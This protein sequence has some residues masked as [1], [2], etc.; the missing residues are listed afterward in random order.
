MDPRRICVVGSTN[1]DVV[2]HVDRL[3][4]PGE[5]LMADSLAISPGGKGAN[6]A[7]AAAR[8]GSL[9]RFSTR[10]GRDAFGRALYDGLLEA[11]IE[12]DSVLWDDDAPT[13]VAGI[14][15]DASG[16]N[17]ITVAA[18]ANLRLTAE[19]ASAA[20]SASTPRVVLAQLE[21]PV[22]AV[23]AAFEHRPPGCL[24]VLNP[25][26]APDFNLPDR[27]LRLT[28][29][30]TPNETETERLT[31]IRPVDAATCLEA[32][33]KLRDR[34]AGAVVITRGRSGCFVLD[35]SGYEVVQG[36]AVRA[37]DSTAAGDAFNGALA[38]SLARGLSLTEAAGF[39][40][41]AAA[42]SVTRRGAQAAMPTREEVDSAALT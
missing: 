10:L 23:Q 21:V 3:P 11:G 39:A 37:V 33:I 12:A 40:N 14:L 41:R 7:V 2:F 19:D 1:M 29:V 15:V 25:A 27:L 6:Q 34:G 17:V 24:S 26:P 31:G 18:G 9:V 5:T 30:I 8:L 22:A 32:A 28:D 13:G 42:V 4:Q 20:T 38:D 16:Q 36:H 35:G